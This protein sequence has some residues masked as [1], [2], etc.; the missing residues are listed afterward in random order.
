MGFYF[1]QKQKVAKTFNKDFNFLCTR[2]CDSAESTI[3]VI[4]ALLCVVLAR[5]PRR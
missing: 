1:L 3:E 4:A 5:N 2:F